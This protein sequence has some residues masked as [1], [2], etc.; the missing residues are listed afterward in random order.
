M[1]V[2]IDFFYSIMPNGY[3]LCIKISIIMLGMLN[4]ATVIYLLVYQEYEG[5]NLYYQNMSLTLE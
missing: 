2:L 1:Q 3:W 4:I 5:C